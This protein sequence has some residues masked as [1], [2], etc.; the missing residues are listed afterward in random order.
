MICERPNCGKLVQNGH[1]YWFPDSEDAI[2]WCDDCFNEFL[3]Y[4]N[5]AGCGHPHDKEPE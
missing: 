4:E 1:G 5:I 3:L 2:Y